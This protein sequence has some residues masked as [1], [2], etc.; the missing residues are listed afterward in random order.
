VDDIGIGYDLLY[1]NPI[2]RNVQDIA[3]GFRLPIYQYDYNQTTTRNGIL[4]NYPYGT[5]VLSASS[6]SFESNSMI[7]ESLWGVEDL[8]KT[9]VTVGGQFYFASFGFSS[10]VSWFEKQIL[11]QRNVLINAHT[12]CDWWKVSLQ[13]SVRPALSNDFVQSVLMLPPTYNSES[14]HK[15]YKKFIH[16]G[17]GSHYITQ[18]ILGGRSQ[19]QLHTSEANYRH[20]V[21]N[22]FN[23]QQDMAVKWHLEFKEEINFNYNKTEYE[24]FSKI[25]TGNSIQALGGN[26]ILVPGNFTAWKDSIQDDPVPTW[27]YLEPLET[28]LTPE[29]FP[30]D[31]RI[32]EKAANFKTAVNDYLNNHPGKDRSFNLEKE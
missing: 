12:N 3:E 11:E 1:G 32:S 9:Q 24:E 28:V 31:K 25:F 30:Q 18:M 27:Y 26:P 8:I 7:I 14:D 2:A 22:G 17:F 16:S 15:A 13:Y 23:L 19:Q 10:T 4:W 6:C 29:N 20:V 21:S 5:A